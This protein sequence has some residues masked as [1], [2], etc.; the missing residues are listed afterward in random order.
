VS[1]IRISLCANWPDELRRIHPRITFSQIEAFGALAEAD[2]LVT[3]EGELTDAAQR[4]A[5]GVAK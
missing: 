3:D 2:N 4:W 1:L 5:R